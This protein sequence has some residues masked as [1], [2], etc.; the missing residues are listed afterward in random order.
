MYSTLIACLL[1]LGSVA[2]PA[3]LLANPLNEDDQADTSIYVARDLATAKIDAQINID[4]VLDEA[5]WLSAEVA[6]DFITINPDPGQSSMLKSEVRILYDNNA[7]YIGAFLYDPNPDSIQVTL[8]ERDETGNADWFSVM[9][10]PYRDG[11]NAVSFGVTAAGVQVDALWSGFGND[12]NWD[13]VWESSVRMDENGWYVEYRIPYYAIRFPSDDEQI[14]GI[15][16]GR[17]IRRTREESWWSP[18]N[19]A[20]QGMIQQVGNLHGIKDIQA[21]LRLSLFPYVS[22]Y[23]EVQTDPQAKTNATGYDVNGGMDLKYGITDAFTLDMT[24]IPD[25]GQVEF[26]DQVLNLSPFEVRFDEKRPF[27]M[28]GTELFNKAGLFYSRRVGGTPIGFWEVTDQL[29]E[30][31]EI[32]SNPA[33][34]RLLNAS[35]ISGRTN[36]GLG[37]G[38]FNAV[39]RR[40]V[41]TVS[42]G[43]G[44]TRTIETSPLTN[45]N[46]LVLDQNIKNRSNSYI[47]FTNTNVMRNGHWYDANTTGLMFS[48][49]DKKDKYQVFTSGALSQK[50]QSGF[51]SVDLGHRGSIQ[52]SK[53]QGNLTWGLGYAEESDTYDPNDLGFLFNNNSR[54]WWINGNYNIYEPF[55][56]LNGLYSW[57]WAGYT[58]IYNPNEFSN[59]GTGGGVTLITKKFFATGLNMNA[60]PIVT[61]DF[62]EPRVQGRYFTYPINWNTNAWISSDYRKKFA[63][64]AWAFYRWFDDEGR[65]SYALNI[66][67]RWRIN[68][69]VTVIAGYE[70]NTLK[71]DVGWANFDD[72]D[73]IFAER[74]VTINITSIN[75]SYIF[76]PNLWF[77]FRLRHYWSKADYLEFHLLDEEGYLVETDYTGIDP[78]TDE[79]LHNV[80][81]NAFT[82]DAGLNWR[83]APGSDMTIVWKNAIFDS[84][85][86]L[87]RNYFDNLGR[88]FNA[89]QSNNLSV[90]IVY[91]LDYVEMRN[92]V[93]GNKRGQVQLDDVPAS[94]FRGQNPIPFLEQSRKAGRQYFKQSRRTPGWS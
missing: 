81:F 4:G 14:W 25:F 45:Y 36:G 10:S 94:S 7:L 59:L 69:K 30:G 68:D 87:E 76:T 47:T 38:V 13:A 51:D 3:S 49:R 80:N 91:F 1:L 46:V 6:S 85:S 27:F 29:E 66:E 55:W 54:D 8:S 21:P 67:P 58:R 61:Y 82:I 22:S 83:F 31:E 48:L 42:N 9:L 44:E 57:F 16:F 50:Y 89:L 5:E 60:E 23:F 26:D 33:V 24:L 70:T 71:E 52:F 19:P 88:T 43:E 93:G 11:N 12:Q 2:A 74:D 20:E 75:A 86:E 34:V 78:E 35:K 32:E 62:F 18:I 41:A 77:T 37:I 92:W 28:E 84:G 64:D 17:S 56:K 39:A 15:N 72:E 79:S 90:R 63:I 73:I 65:F 53:V 40:E